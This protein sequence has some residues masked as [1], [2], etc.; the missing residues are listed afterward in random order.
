MVKKEGQKKDHAEPQAGKQQN[1]HD[2][3]EL[4]NE[5]RAFPSIQSSVGPSGAKAHAGQRVC[6]EAHGSL[7]CSPKALDKENQP[8]ESSFPSQRP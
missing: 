2:F 8:Q 6:R 4:I 5:I 3:K 1:F 7:G